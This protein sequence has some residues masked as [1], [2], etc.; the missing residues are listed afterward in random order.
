MFAHPNPKRA[1]IIGGGEGATLREILKHQSIEKVKMIEIDGEMV[2]FSRTHLPDWNSCA[3]IEG[4][5]EWCGD[6]E[7]ADIHNEDGM[8]WFHN[9]F[10]DDGKIDSDEF[11]EEPF[12]ILIIDALDPQD[13]VAF[14]DILYTNEAFIKTLYNALSDDGIIVMQLGQSPMTSNPSEQFSTDSKRAF[15]MSIFEKLGFKSVHV[16]EEG[17]CQFRNPWSYAVAMKG[18]SGKS[19]WYR[20]AAEI[21]V[22]IRKRTFKSISGKP[23]LKYF[24]GG[25]MEGYQRPPKPFERVFCRSV[26]MPESCKYLGED[27]V[28]V[29]EQ[30][31]KLYDPV[32]DR[33]FSQ[34]RGEVCDYVSPLMKKGGA[35]S[36]SV[37]ED[38]KAMCI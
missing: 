11:R 16:F 37:P 7:R 8:A 17:H 25:V 36:E 14:A 6:D 19:L 29:S 22:A 31:R 13:N 12:D 10:S 30:G 27:R 32:A 9:R 18:D 3:D 1:A 33:H 23:T 5:A 15:V 21:D 34:P 28:V 24:D 35:L 20:N 2:S 4:S 38:V 26:P